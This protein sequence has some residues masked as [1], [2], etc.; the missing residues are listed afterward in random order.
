[1]T[2]DADID[3]FLSGAV[4]AV[5][6]ASSDRR[7]YGNKILRCY[8]QDDRVA[9]PV[10][11]RGGIIEGQPS[12]PRLADVPASVHGVSLIT[13]PAV[14]AQVVD[15]ALSLGIRHLWFQP[16]SEDDAAIARARAAGATV[17][18]DGAC[19]LVVLG[20]REGDR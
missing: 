3:S 4:F 13:Q 16:G 6:G 1:M 19:L 7:K 14:S 15:E 20:Y 12:Y 9:Y 5:A 8:W 11:P 17:I 18:A 10:N 2:L